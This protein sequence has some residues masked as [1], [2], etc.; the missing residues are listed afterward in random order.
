MPKKSDAPVR[1]P[2]CGG[3]QRPGETTFTSDSG[4]TV[5]VVRQVPA[6]VCDQ[7]GETFI[8]AKVA[9]QLEKMVASAR[10]KGAQVEILTAAHLAAP[11]PS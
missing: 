11:S 6:M 3:F 9:R 10:R 2:V 1:C 5:V 8:N 7:C 4:G